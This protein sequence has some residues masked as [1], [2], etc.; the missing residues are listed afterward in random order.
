M[1][2]PGSII[3]LILETAYDVSSCFCWN[4]ISL[5][6]CAQR[7]RFLVVTRV[8]LEE[9]VEDNHEHGCAS[10]EDREGVERTV[11]DH[12]VV[13]KANTGELMIVSLL[14]V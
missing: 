11:G 3:T 5:S 8:D 9:M 6:L 10:Q 14:E 13:C 12:F 4:C 7:R 2:S 1:H